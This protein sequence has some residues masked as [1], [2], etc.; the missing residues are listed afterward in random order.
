MLITKHTD[1]KLFWQELKIG[2]TNCFNVLFRKY[3]SELHQYGLKIF[4]DQEFVKETIQEVFIRIWET[5][6]RLGEVENIKAYLLVSLRRMMLTKLGKDKSKLH[7]E[8]GKA[9]HHSFLF[10]LNEFEK[11]EELSPEIRDVILKSVNSLTK[12][13]RELIQLFFYHEL[14]YP[15]IA[16]VMKMSIKATRNL[17]YRTLI[18]LRESIGEKMLKTMKDMFVLFF[19]TTPEKKLE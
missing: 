11:Q 5:R 1:D 8:F 3:Y 18:H 9:N 14:P 6:E 16:K 12:R 2:D 17:M 15:E 13:Q 19:L 7:V 10:E 4:S